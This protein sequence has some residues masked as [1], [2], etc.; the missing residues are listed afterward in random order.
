MK[1][2]F[3]LLISLMLLTSCAIEKQQIAYTV[4]PLGYLLERI[5]DGE[6]EVVS[7]QTDEIV[8]RSTLLYN[9]QETLENSSIFYHIGDLEPYI[10]IYMED[11][12][13]TG[14]II[15]D[16]SVLNA[17]YPFQR[18]T[19]VLVEG[20]ETFIEGPYYTG[21]VF[22][23]I[24][25]TNRDLFLW[26]DPIAMLSIA[27]DMN[28]YF[29]SNYAEKASEFNENYE[30]L[31]LELYTLDSE[32]QK[33]STSLKENNQEIK[34]VSMTASFG[35]W[36]K[37][38]GFQVYPLILSQYGAL[39]TEEQLA[40]IMERIEKDNVQYI[41]YEPNMTPDMIELFNYVE[42][43]LNLTRVN[44]SNLS[45]LTTSQR[46]QNQNYM[47]IMYENLATLSNMIVNI[48]E[49][50]IVDEEVD[51]ELETSDEEN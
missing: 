4:Y 18:Y 22:E 17:I 33:L 45:S 7:I 23:T 44:L 31:E 39:P 15:D 35:N 30:K 6:F 43:T 8:Q 11:I 14:V 51:E 19:R 10:D 28:T 26:I 20:N 27:K 38:Y 5:T 21:E 25:T 34:F 2:L 36:Q 42:D 9:Y 29:T 48:G 47:S 50:K 24:D 1:K 41:V 37:N 13:D 40:I 32:Y 3:I 49:E 12:E 16:V 46:D